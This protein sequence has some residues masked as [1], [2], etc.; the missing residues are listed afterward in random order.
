LVL[1]T[2]FIPRYSFWAAAAV[3]VLTE[4]LI[5]VLTSVYLK[6]KYQ[7][8]ISGQELKNNLF[9]LLKKRKSFFDF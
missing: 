8:T 9:L 1:N 4:G 3:T 2:I 5:F 7:L 6:R